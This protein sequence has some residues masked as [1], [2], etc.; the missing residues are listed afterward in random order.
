MVL[1]I[2]NSA[3][4]TQ[5]ALALSIPVRPVINIFGGSF[6]GYAR[7]LFVTKYSKRASQANTCTPGNSCRPPRFLY[8][9]HYE[10]TVQHSTA[11][12]RAT[13]T[14]FPPAVGSAQT[15]LSAPLSSEVQ[16]AHCLPPPSPPA[17]PLTLFPPGLMLPLHP[18]VTIVE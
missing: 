3:W 15:S 5:P 18:K 7:S 8:P 14:P 13:H 6:E 16:T 9:R 11:R 17:P 10:N 2:L 1:C 4:E 12:R